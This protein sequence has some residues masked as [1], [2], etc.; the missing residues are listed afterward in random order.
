MAV[1]NATKIPKFRGKKKE[2]F[3]LLMTARENIVG[4][5][6]FHA[7]EALTKPGSG[8]E[9]RGMATHMADLGSDNSRHEMELQ[10][11]T[12]EG[13]VLERIEEALERLNNNEYGNCLDCGDD[14]PDARLRAKPHAQCCIKCKS[15]REKNGGINPYID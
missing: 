1:K 13:D 6:E 12:E 15:I 2:F 3:E 14:I 5:M 10:L 9:S 11:L 4:Q 7:G 8:A